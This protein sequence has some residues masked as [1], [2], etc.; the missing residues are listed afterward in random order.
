MIVYTDASLEVLKME[1]DAEQPKAELEISPQSSG[2]NAR[3][4]ALTPAKRTAIARRAALVRWGSEL[5]YATHDGVLRL[6]G[7]DILCAVLN[8]RVRVLT[9]E[10]MLTAIGRAGKAKGGTGVWGVD[11][12]PPFL[13]ADNLN[14]FI[15]ERLRESTT[16]ILFRGKNGSPTMGFDARLLPMV[17][18]V[19]LKAGLDGKLTKTQKPIAN[20][21]RLLQ[22]A[23]AEMGIVALV[24]DATGF[25]DD[26]ARD[27]LTKLLEAYIAPELAAWT[28]RFPHE[29]FRQVY[30]LHGW[31]YKVGI[32]RGP[33]YVGKFIMKYVWGGLPK[34][35]V[36]EIK[37]RNP[38]DEHGRRPKKLFQFLTDETGIPH[39]D[40]QISSI[41]T[42]MRASTD[43][44]QFEE[45][46]ARAFAIARPK[47][48][49]LIGTDKQ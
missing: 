17:C 33:R 40:W 10:T 2:G 26:Q 18:D 38:N 3:A 31:P 37:R 46:F 41:T 1:R 27:G 32:T 14:G 21:C 6:A 49:E 29:F 16:P 13:S 12:L 42:L 22:G 34:D 39:L 11:D 48:L 30:R 20:I 9:Q 5:P 43:K 19:Y 24:D 44:E 36:D 23:F 8:T 25:S 15:S 35:V 47:Q 45:L 7:R 4:Q 28:Q